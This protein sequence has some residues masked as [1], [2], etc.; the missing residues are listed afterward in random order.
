MSNERGIIYKYVTEDRVDVLE[1]RLI[2]FTSHRN[3]NDPFE[4]QFALEPFQREREA[5]EK[6]G[7]AAEQAEV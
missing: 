1:N 5:A 2:R 4:C 3:L 7:F 6:D